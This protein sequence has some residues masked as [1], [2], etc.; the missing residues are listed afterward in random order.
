MPTLI[1]PQGRGRPPKTA[2]DSLRTRLW[3]QA[4]KLASGL[5]SA[6]AI[7]IHLEPE[8]VRRKVGGVVRPRKWDH[9]EAGSR[10]PK[11]MKG[12]QYAVDLAE[13][14]FA[15]TA[16]YYESPLWK[17]LTNGPIRPR[18]LDQQLCAL[19]APVTDILLEAAPREGD[20]QR[21]FLPFDAAAAVALAELRSFEALAA[22]VL[23]IAK[24]EAIASLELRDLAMA[25]YRQI[26]LAMV[27]HPVVQPLAGE[28]L[29]S[30]D[31]TCK[32]WV[33]PSPESRMDIVIFS[34]EVRRAVEEDMA[35]GVDESASNEQ[36]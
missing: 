17:V 7:E 3:F 20:T 8:L 2:V 13:R 35:H 33:F 26:Q 28:L 34:D 11:R 9:Y 29:R 5:A 23:L 24:S 19:S 27:V 6:Y 21:R 25:S 1:Q 30:I 14:H 10:S 12:K 18:W 15:G 32:H 4:V 22:I 31:Q 16:G 36:G